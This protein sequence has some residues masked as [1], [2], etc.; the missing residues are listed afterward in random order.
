MICLVCLERN[1]FGCSICLDSNEISSDQYHFIII[2]EIPVNRTQVLRSSTLAPD[3]S[4]ISLAL[5]KDG[6][7]Y[8][9]TI[10]PGDQTKTNKPVLIACPITWTPYI[11]CW[12]NR[13]IPGPLKDHKTS[14]QRLF[15]HRYKDSTNPFNVGGAFRKIVRRYLGAKYGCRPHGK[16][17]N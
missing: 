14:K 13:I 4:Q 10:K 6:K 15:V 3:E 2:G 9:L 7:A 5:D 11:N 8:E 12:V 1:F 17:M 16:Y